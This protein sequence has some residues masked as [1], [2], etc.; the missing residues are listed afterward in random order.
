MS[1][2][3]S[4]EAK[5][6]DKKRQAEKKTRR[7]AVRSSSFVWHDC[8]GVPNCGCARWCLRCNAGGKRIKNPPPP[9]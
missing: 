4:T 9:K 5:A 2:F 8:G 3:D 1:W 6:R 7:D